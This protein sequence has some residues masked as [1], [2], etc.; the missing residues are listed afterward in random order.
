MVIEAAGG[1]RYG[2]RRNHIDSRTSRADGVV[3]PADCTF[4]CRCCADATENIPNYTFEAF[5]C[6]DAAEN[7]PNYTF[8]ALR[9][10][11]AAENIPNYTFEALRC[12]DRADIAAVYTFQTVSCLDVAFLTLPNEQEANARTQKYPAQLEP[13]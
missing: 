1:D 4:N 2:R 12:A 7:V 13:G 8:E 6:A 9:C 11:D 5:R 3:F 10:A